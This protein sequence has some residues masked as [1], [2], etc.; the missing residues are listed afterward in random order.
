MNSL[1]SLLVH[2]EMS[3]TICG[4]FECCNIVGNLSN[5]F[6]IRL[7]FQSPGYIITA[8]AVQRRCILSFCLVQQK[9]LYIRIQWES[10]EEFLISIYCNTCTLI[11]SG[12]NLISSLANGM[13][14][15][16]N[17][18]YVWEIHYVFRHLSK[19]CDMSMITMSV[20]H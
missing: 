19:D 12:S 20:E 4:A 2:T 7:L 6:S 1:H 16:T 10:Q 5:S 13:V 14:G 3:C 9:I 15:S 17:L 18:Q 8:M 11:V